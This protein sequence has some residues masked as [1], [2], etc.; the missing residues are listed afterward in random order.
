MTLNQLL[1]INISLFIVSDMNA[2][3]A[4]V[5][6]DISLDIRYEKPPSDTI[7]ISDIQNLVPNTAQPLL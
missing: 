5:S 6:P 2:R 7:S 4:H 1:I 3:Y